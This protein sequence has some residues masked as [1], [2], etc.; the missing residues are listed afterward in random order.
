MKAILVID[1][2]QCCEECD[3]CY[4]TDKYGCMVCEDITGEIVHDWYRKP[5]WCPLK[6][7]PQKS[8]GTFEVTDTPRANT[9]KEG[10]NA[11][12]EEIER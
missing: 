12:L 3:L 8:D 5:L 11:C 6:P 7:M 4:H 10:W 2:P 1:M 9:F